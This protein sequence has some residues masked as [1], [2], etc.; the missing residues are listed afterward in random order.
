M[1][2]V[3][4]IIGPRYLPSVRRLHTDQASTDDTNFNTSAAASAPQT[5]KPGILAGPRAARRHPPILGPYPWNDQLAPATRDAY[6]NRWDRLS[7]S[8]FSDLHCSYAAGFNPASNGVS[9]RVCASSR[10]RVK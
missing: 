1:V 6:R 5:H 4:A 3:R 10:P 2:R 7:T 9:S 8:L